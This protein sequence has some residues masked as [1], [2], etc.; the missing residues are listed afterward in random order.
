MS[1]GR[2]AA[3]TKEVTLLKAA[4]ESLRAGLRGKEDSVTELEREKEGLLEQVAGLESATAENL[5]LGERVTELE[6]QVKGLEDELGQAEA[7]RAMTMT[8]LETLKSAQNDLRTAHGRVSQRYAELENISEDSAEAIRRGNTLLHSQQLKID[9]QSRQ[10]KRHEEDLVTLR[11][12]RELYLRKADQNEAELAQVQRRES[13]YSMVVRPATTFR[14]LEHKAATSSEMQEA[15]QRHRSVVRKNQD[16]IDAHEKALNSARSELL[17]LCLEAEKQSAR[18][19]KASADAASETSRATSEKNSALREL[20]TSR[21]EKEELSDRLEDT[22]RKLDELQAQQREQEKC[23]VSFLRRDITLQGHTQAGLAAEAA[24]KVMATAMKNAGG[25]GR[26][27]TALQPHTSSSNDRGEVGG[28]QTRAYEPARQRQLQNRSPSLSTATGIDR[29]ENSFHPQQDH[30]APFQSNPLA[31]PKTTAREGPDERALSSSLARPSGNRALPR[32]LAGAPGKVAS[33]SKDIAADDDA[34]VSALSPFSPSPNF[35]EIRVAQPRKDRSASAAFPEHGGQKQD[36]VMPSGGAASGGGEALSRE[37]DGP[38]RRESRTDPSA[39]GHDVASTAAKDDTSSR[40]SRPPPRSPSE[41]AGASD[42]GPDDSGKNDLE[43]IT[44]SG[45]SSD[46]SD[47]PDAGSRRKRAKTA[48]T[49]SHPAGDTDGADEVGRTVAIPPLPSPLLASAP[50]AHQHH[51]ANVDNPGNGGAPSGSEFAPADEED[52]EGTCPTCGDS[53]YGLM[54]NCSG[55]S[56]QHHSSCVPEARRVGKGLGS[57][58]RCS[59][60]IDEV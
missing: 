25:E 38:G 11:A 50:H 5:K 33:P 22:S 13:A 31:K 28:R 35:G 39:G 55:C 45:A 29:R 58:F 27:N 34:S 12:E 49:R 19:Q 18:H 7:G 2:D 17:S 32:E 47:A 10:I 4:V 44:A 41:S 14:R 21:I 8:M 57:V 30:R 20:R 15:R 43:G 51:F 60:C 9:A 16:V 37:L 1:G 3:S 46:A 40:R 56:R 53:P 54:I 23:L 52:G 42:F 6:G 36:V 24:T 48:A 26:I 59:K